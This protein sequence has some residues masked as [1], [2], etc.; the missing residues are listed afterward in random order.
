MLGV[1]LWSDPV[2]HKAV[3]WCEDHGD[4]AYFKGTA[5][6]GASADFDSGDLVQF[7]ILTESRLRRALNPKLVAERQFPTLLEDLAQAK[8]TVSAQ[9]DRPPRGGQVV[10]FATALSQRMAGRLERAL[11]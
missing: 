10:S 4:L 11:A 1:V 5:H 7:E 3:I 6:D 8:P 2:E 9:K